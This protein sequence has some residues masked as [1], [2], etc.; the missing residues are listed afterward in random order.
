MDK[1]LQK[2][3][4]SSRKHRQYQPTEVFKRLETILHVHS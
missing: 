2:K 4:A 3:Q 1:H